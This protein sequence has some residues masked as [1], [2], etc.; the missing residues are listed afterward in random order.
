MGR[1]R[2]LKVPVPPLEQQHEFAK[3]IR[4]VERVKKQQYEHLA[5]LVAVFK[6]LQSRAFAGEL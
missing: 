5:H 1:L 2:E 6:S 4:S 3:I